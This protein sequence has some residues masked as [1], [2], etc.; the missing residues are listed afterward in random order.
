MIPKAIPAGMLAALLLG[1][2]SQPVPQT[3]AP[4]FGFSVVADSVILF[5][6]RET[7]WGVEV[8]DQARN[9]PLYSHNAERHFIPA[10]NTK[11]VVTT[12]AMGMLGPEWRYQTPVQ[13]A[14]A[15]GDSAP[16]ALI[17]KGSGDPTMSARFFGND[18]A[19]LDSLADSLA[20]KGIK[21]I[22]GD[23]IIDASMFAPER[24]H[25]SWEIGDLPWYYAAPTTTFAVG[26]A[27]V[28]MIATASDVQFVGAAPVPVARHILTDTVGA[29]SN[30]DVAYEAW[31]DTLVVVGSIAPNRADSSWIAQPDPERYAAQALIEALRRK[32]ITVTGNVRIVRDSAEVAALPARTTLFTWQSP[33]VKSIV[34]GLLR[35]SQNWIAEQLLKTLGAVQGRGGS[36]RAGLAVERRYLI[37][38]AH[39]D[40]TA[41]SLSDGSGLSAQNLLSPRAFVQLLEHARRSSWGSLYHDALPTPGMRG[42]TL[43]S[44]L[45]GLETRVAAKTGSIANVNSLSGYLQAADGRNLTFSI[46]SNGSGRSSAEIRRGIDAL[47]Q[48]LAREKNWD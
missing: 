13:V 39:V 10:S 3:P 27:A 15:A 47:V 35:P 4:R 44:R 9:Q 1:A 6:L 32:S 40:S 42:G 5:G 23:V 11:L 21:R 46:L 7:Q 2:C 38:V 18:F 16:G 24:V 34:A 26:E 22:A 31:P 14:G 28:R 8:W 45:P 41:F 36:W 37:D 12:V 17:I 43:S 20:V 19:V 25:S 33:P 29:R 30:I 48:A